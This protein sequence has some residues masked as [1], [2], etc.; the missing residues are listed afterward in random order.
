MGIVQSDLMS[1]YNIK[2]RHL[3]IFTIP[4]E[5]MS[6]LSIASLRRAR[7][8]SVEPFFSPSE[9]VVNNVGI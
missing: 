7:K 1:S 2:S 5:A 6:T 9:K 4:F 8:S 3:V